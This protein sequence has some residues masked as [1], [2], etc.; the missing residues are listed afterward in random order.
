M[1][2]VSGKIEYKGVIYKL[3]FNLNVME[4]I[5]DEYGTI[6][7]WGEITDGSS[8]EPNAKAVKFGF[9]AM[10]NEGID[11]M[12]EENG[13]EIKKFTLQQVGRM[14]SDMGLD[15]ATAVLNQTVVESTKSEEKNG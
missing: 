13:T 1:K 15:N 10:L 9:Q 5:Q 14:L 11:I 3:V 2:D 4:T 7:H 6:E 8:G 12:N